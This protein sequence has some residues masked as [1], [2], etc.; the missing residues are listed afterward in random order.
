MKI[1]A[2]VMDV[3]GTLTDGGIFIGVSGEVM[4]KFYV[5]DGYAIKH[6]LP[7]MHILPIVITGRKSEIVAR[8]CGELDIVHLCQGSVDKMTDLRRMLAQEQ[9]MLEETAYIGDDINDLE[10]LQAAALSGCPADAAPEVQAAADFIA[11]SPGGC[12]AVR[13][14][15]EWIKAN[16][17]DIDSE[18]DNQ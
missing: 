14:F 3:D 8:R 15:I 11:P 17:K 9:I 7:R 4:K 18:R 5:R 2:L 13:E 16:E 6:M 1:R 10:C 12:G